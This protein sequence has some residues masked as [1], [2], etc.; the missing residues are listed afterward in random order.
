MTTDLGIGTEFAGHRIEAVAARGGMGVIYRATHLR[1]GRT[2]GLKLVASELAKDSSRRERFK[3]ESRIAASIDH[4][5]VIPVYEAGEE[6]GILFISMRWVDGTDLRTMVELDGPLDQ[7][8]A[9]NLISQV[10]DALDAAHARNLI[11]RDVKPANVLVTDQDHVYLTDF[12]LSRHVA[13]E[14]DLTSAGHWV[15]SVDYVAP[16]QIQGLPVSPRTDVYSLGCVLYELLAGRAPYV[17]ETDIAKLWAHVNAAPPSLLPVRPDLPPKFDQIVRRATA[18]SPSQRYESA[19]ALGE[20]V[21]A[22]AGMAKEALRGAREAGAARSGGDGSVADTTQL[23]LPAV[24]RAR[25]RS[26]FVG[27]G[28]H[29]DRMRE[30]WEDARAGQLQLVL[31]A[32]EA[33]IGKTRLASEFSCQAHEEG[34]TVLYGRSDEDALVPYQSFVEALGQWVA[35]SP[36]DHLLDKVAT[37]AQ[38]SRLLPQ[39]AQRFPELPQVP[40]R[41]PDTERFLLFEAVSSLLAEESAVTPIVLVL[42]DLHWADKSTLALLKHLSRSPYESRLLIVGPYREQFRTDHLADTLADLHREQ[43]FERLSLK[44]LEQPDVEALISARSGREAEPELA[45]A[46]NDETE[47]NPFFIE[48]VVRHLSES[49][50]IFDRNGRW[51]SDL[52]IDQLGIPESLKEVIR[53]RLGHLDDQTAQ[54]LSLASIAGRE[55]DLQV[56]EQVSDRAADELLESLDEALAA[57]LIDDVPGRVGRY[58]F[59]HAL[60]HETLYDDHNAA[61]RVRLHR[62]IGEAMERIHADSSDPPL[63]ELAHHFLKSA[64]AGL[65]VDKAIGYAIG[66]GERAS[67]QLAHKE[68]AVFYRR[69]L[70][71]VEANDPGN[72]ERSCELLLSLGQAEWRAGDFDEAKKAF[73][74]AAGLAQ[75][76]G[77]SEQLARAALGFGGPFAAFE[78]GKVDEPLVDLLE[79]ALGSLGKDD[80]EL[81][82]R[83]TSR[84]AE[85]LTFSQDRDRGAELSEQAVAMARRLGDRATL[86]YALERAH[87]ATWGPENLDGRLAVSTEVLELAEQAGEIGAAMQI[88]VWRIAHLL[89]SADI[90]AVDDEVEACRGLASRLR[91]PYN[92]WQVATIDATLALLEGRFSEVEQLSLEALAIGQ[93]AENRNAV[94]L[95]GVQ[96]LSLRRE[97]GRLAEL[98]QDMATFVEQYPGIPGWRAGLA[99]LHSELGQEPEARQWFEQLASDFTQL[100]RDMFWLKSI[101]LLAE[102]CAYLGDSERA[103]FLYEW[104]APYAERCVVD[105]PVA[106]CSGSVARYLGLLAA[107]LGRHD[108]AAAHFESAIAVNAGI[109]AWPWVAHTRH[110]LA[111]MLLARREPGDRERALELVGEALA[112]AEELGMKSLGERTRSL[113]AEAEGVTVD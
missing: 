95:C 108:Q 110:D 8:R 1:L 84:L 72:A 51:A 17:R 48:E 25:N 98:E 79:Q 11:H 59:S 83:V 35:A 42:D 23:P 85:A 27:R 81:R 96:I 4:P 112:A 80:S 113:K 45:Q 47:G 29:L 43:Q 13:S 52:T 64:E 55:F 26:A 76:L 19:D 103:A 54:M 106:A 91:Q 57:Q 65:D 5:N 63:S 78:T 99:S 73:S 68:A 3:R 90:A 97:E 74:R 41:E 69:A 10:A 86:A 66:A 107:T 56:L 30:R 101:S 62:Q 16:E 82:A 28:P 15:G 46:I 105:A 77:G 67:S 2:V 104:L 60:I 39:L 109:R 24:L 61:R 22:A 92:L 36:S 88:R 21:L 44:G 49:G 102:L 40:E 38:L 111:A 14:D 70:E 31:L 18:K 89:E 50:A 71:T 100:P 94:A 75:A 9:A 12:G 34:A 37:R 20:A 58:S 53:Q 7:A 32:G 33:G 6:E 87:W 93:E